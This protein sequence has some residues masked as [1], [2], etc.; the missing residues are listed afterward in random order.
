[1]EYTLMLA[2]VIAALLSAIDILGPSTSDIFMAT[3]DAVDIPD[4]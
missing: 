1:M 3:S 2:L 4:N